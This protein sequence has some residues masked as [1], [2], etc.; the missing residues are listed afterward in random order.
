M[1]AC[2][3]VGKGVPQHK[4]AWLTWA[5]AHSL[6]PSPQPALSPASAAMARPHGTART[7]RTAPEAPGEHGLPDQHLRSMRLV[8]AQAVRRL[9]G[10]DELLWEA[11]GAARLL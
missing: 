2:R 10:H 3:C 9:A 6:L 7:R 1:S 5:L 8:V 4:A 11:L